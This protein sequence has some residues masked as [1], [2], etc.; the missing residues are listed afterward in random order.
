M[1]IAVVCQGPRPTRHARRVWVWGFALVVLVQPSVA[2]AEGRRASLLHG[3]TEVVRGVLWVPPK[4]VVEATV[5][6][7]PVVGTGVGILGAIPQGLQTIFRGLREIGDVV[8]RVGSG[9]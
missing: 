1:V 2:W 8:C 9:G 4:T 5:N 3:M 7:P 6:E